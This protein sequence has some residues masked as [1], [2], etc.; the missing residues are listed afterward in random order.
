M[1][2]KKSF[3]QYRLWAKEYGPVYSLIL[4]Q[5]TVIVLADRNVIHEL[6]DVKGSNYA[7]RPDS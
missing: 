2:K 6:V 1:P 4:G 3:E 5:K 7:D